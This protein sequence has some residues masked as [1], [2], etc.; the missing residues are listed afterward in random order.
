MYNG[1]DQKTITL[2]TIR[3]LKSRGE[4]IA[5]LTAYDST[6]AYQ[7]DQAGIEIIFQ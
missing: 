6:F 4:K 3:E 7:L 2:S 1:K 5:C